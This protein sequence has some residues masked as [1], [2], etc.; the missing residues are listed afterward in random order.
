MGKREF[1]RGLSTWAVVLALSL[2]SSAFAQGSYEVFAGYLT[3]TSGSPVAG[4][5][6]SVNG[7]SSTT[8]TDG[9]FELYPPAAEKYIINAAASRL[10]AAL[11]D[12]YGTGPSRTCT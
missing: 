4:G 5:T 8:G 12:I 1:S 6:V 7:Q 3:N 11:P 9:Y 2:G 10:R